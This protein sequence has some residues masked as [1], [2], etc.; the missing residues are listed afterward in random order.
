[1]VVV[2]RCVDT[3]AAR[4]LRGGAR[5]RSQQA[6]MVDI[7]LYPE[8]MEHRS[9]LGLLMTAT[10]RSEGWDVQQPALHTSPRIRPLLDS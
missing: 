7:K 1:M 9:V 3:A 10:V 4:V 6:A 2:V 5:L 8:T